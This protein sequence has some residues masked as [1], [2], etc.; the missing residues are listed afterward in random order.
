MV[1]LCKIL[2]IFISSPLEDYLNQ[3]THHLQ[4]TQRLHRLLIDENMPYFEYYGGL[5][6]TCDNVLSKCDHC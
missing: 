6:S 1:Q 5:N 2:L 3:H 4:S